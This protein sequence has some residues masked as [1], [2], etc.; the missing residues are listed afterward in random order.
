MR[1]RWRLRLCLVKA[2]APVFFLSSRRL[3]F[4]A[5][6]VLTLSRLIADNSPAL[7]R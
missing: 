3:F 2:R 1:E 7:G 4:L 6:A 5:A